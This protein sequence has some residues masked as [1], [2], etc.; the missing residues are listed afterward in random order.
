M[1]V[2]A[3]APNTIVYS[4]KKVTQKEMATAGFFLNIVGIILTTGVCYL[5]LPL[6]FGFNVSTL[7]DW[8]KN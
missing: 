1:L 6:L 5:L 3:T 4:T 8:A 7:P 2:I